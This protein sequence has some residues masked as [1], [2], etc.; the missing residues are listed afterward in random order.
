MTE[1]NVTKWKI[2]K[3]MLFIID[4]NNFH[5]NQHLCL[6]WDLYRR[7]ERCFARVCFARLFGQNRQNG[8]YSTASIWSCFRSDFFLFRFAHTEK[9]RTGLQ[10]MER[11]FKWRKQWCME[12]TLHSKIGP[13]S[14][15]LRYIVIGAHLQIQIACILSRVESPWLLT[16]YLY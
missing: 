15:Q 16:K 2:G 11:I 12:D 4:C 5:G 8:R 14:P 6:V 3:L 9:L 13:R 1:T 10:T 7:A